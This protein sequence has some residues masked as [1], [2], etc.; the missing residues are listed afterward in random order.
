MTWT[1][2]LSAERLGYWAGSG[3]LCLRKYLESKYVPVV[4]ASV[5]SP[6]LHNRVRER[7]PIPGA[8]PR[9]LPEE[10]SLPVEKIPLSLASMATGSVPEKFLPVG[11]L[12]EALPHVRVG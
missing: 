7:V 3:E 10:G 12:A 11:S 1:R 8:G 5:R 2:L 4:D 9:R 6:V